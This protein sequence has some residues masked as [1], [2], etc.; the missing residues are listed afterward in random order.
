[1]KY[2]QLKEEKVALDPVESKI[3]YIFDPILIKEHKLYISDKDGWFYNYY[4]YKGIV[5]NNIL[6][7]IDDA[8]CYGIWDIIQQDSVL[9]FRSYSKF[10]EHENLTLQKMNHGIILTQPCKQL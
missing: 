3:Q 9:Y 10:I 7:W 2:L 5:F 4:E 6:K 8:S 1:M